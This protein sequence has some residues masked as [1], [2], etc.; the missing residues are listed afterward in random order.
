M[1]DNTWVNYALKT[2]ELIIEANLHHPSAP[3]TTQ[4]A[5]NSLNDSLEQILR[6]ATDKCISYK[7][8][9]NSY[10][11]NKPKFLVS[12]YQHLKHLNQIILALRKSNYDFNIWPSHKEWTSHVDLMNRIISFYDLDPIT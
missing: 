3:I 10:F 6:T 12:T 7:W 11:K 1:T 5:L 2:D 9:S 8:S 4:L